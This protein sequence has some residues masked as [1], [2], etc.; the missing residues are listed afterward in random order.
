MKLLKRHWLNIMFVISIL[1][2]W[3]IVHFYFNP[4]PQIEPALKEL[5]ELQKKSSEIIIEMNKLMTSLATLVI[6]GLGVFLLKR[7]DTL[8]IAP[9]KL[10]YYCLWF[11]VIL[12]VILVLVETTGSKQ[13]LSNGPD[14]AA[15]PRLEASGAMN[16]AKASPST[17]TAPQVKD[18]K[19]QE[20]KKDETA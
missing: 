20:V 4:T 9:R 12:F 6:G 16:G 11:S 19:D 7:Y 8:R 18:E 15:A 14:V 17:Q 1:V 13:Q 3:A 5:N 2:I 10:Q